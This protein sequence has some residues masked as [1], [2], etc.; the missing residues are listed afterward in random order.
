MSKLD[1]VKAFCVDNKSDILI[2]GGIFAS[3]VATASMVIAT[4]KAVEEYK[5]HKEALEDISE[6]IED[7]SED[8]NEVIPASDE[9]KR[10][11][12]RRENARFVGKM[13]LLYALPVFAEVVAIVAVISAHNIDKDQKNEAIAMA[14]EATALAASATAKLAAYRKEVVDRFGAQVDYDIYNRR[15]E[16]E[17]V[18]EEVDPKTGKKKQV[19]K[20]V[21]MTDPIDADIYK[22][23]WGPWTSTNWS[24]NPQKNFASMKA[25]VTMMQHKVDACGYGTDVELMQMFELDTTVGPDQTEVFIPNSI[26]WVS[27]KIFDLLPDEWDWKGRHYVKSEY[28]SHVDLGI[29]TARIEMCNDDIF[30]GNTDDVWILRPNCY[31]IDDILEFASKY[32][33]KKKKESLDLDREVL[34]EYGGTRYFDI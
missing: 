33:S 29:D 12:T 5:E 27:S 30:H 19:K 18:T 28:S 21:V 32:I 14:A 34:K 16:V 15:R 13:A 26:G 10:A 22:R 31:S 25:W 8:T 11:L 9:D 4:V 17:V 7:V 23:E 3:I 20:T 24:K 1:N 2:G 6:A